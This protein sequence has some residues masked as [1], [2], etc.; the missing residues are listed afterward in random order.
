MGDVPNPTLDPKVRAGAPTEDE[1]LLNR[2]LPKKPVPLD[3]AA[4]A[5]LDT[6]PWRVLRITGEF[7]HGFNQLAAVGAAVT[8]FGSAR[9]P[10]SDPYYLAAR[11]LGKRLAEAGFAVVTGGGPGIMEAANR[12]A[13]DANGVSVGLN[14]ELPHEQSINPYVTIPVNFRYFFTRKTMLAKYSEGFVMFPGGYGTFDEM[15]E[16]LTLIQTGKLKQFPVI[17]YGSA[18]WKGLVDWL[19]HATLASGYISPKDLDIFQM[20]DSTEEACRILVES[21]CA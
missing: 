16:A 5:W 11:D 15:F 21:Y 18:Y 19:R 3:P 14:I 20:T 9:T 12:G 1:R 17:L 4:T 8:V 2:T 10:E 13:K 7:I 6:D